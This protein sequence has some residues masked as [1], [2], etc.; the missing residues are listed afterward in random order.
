M[1]QTPIQY[2]PAEAPNLLEA[3]LLQGIVDYYQDPALTEQIRHCRVVQREYSGCG[4]FTTLVVSVDSPLII[5]WKEGFRFRAG[6]DIEAPELSD[7][8]GSIL[9]IRE[10]R[11]YFLEVFAH[12]DGDP[13]GLSSFAL[14]PITRTTGSE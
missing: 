2:D 14:L 11:L 9:F 5:E 1:R 12:V 13:A 3:A 10:G 6:N 8:A 4:F 7:G